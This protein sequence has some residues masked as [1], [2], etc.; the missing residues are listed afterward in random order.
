MTQHL[1]GAD[2]GWLARA[3]ALGET[4]RGVSRPNPAVG[5]VVVR[6]GQI[7]G[8]G[9]T[10]PAGGPHAEVVALAEAGATARGA[11]AYVTLEPCA[12]HGR[13]PPC[14][15]A[16]IAE[17]V[18]RVVIG[19]PDPDGVALDGASRLQAAGLAVT[20]PLPATDLFRGVIARQLEGFLTRVT[21]D[22]PHVTLKLA[23][24]GDGRTH[25]AD[26][27]RWVTGVAARRAVHRWRSAV[28]GVLVGSGTVL[29]DDPHLTVR[30]ANGVP[31]TEQPRPLVLDARLRTP[32][33]ATVVARGA[34]VLTS[35]SA[36]PDRIGALRA[37]GAV[38]EVVPAA[39]PIGLQLSRAL[40]AFARHGINSL[41]AEPGR[42]LAQ[43][44]LDADLVDRLV[45]HVGHDVPGTVVV[46]AVAPAAATV[47]RLERFGGAGP[48]AVIQYTRSR[49]T[50]RDDQE[51]A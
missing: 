2:R 14:T 24:T 7:V 39:E 31:A 22:R 8:E 16:L 13:T 44:L 33:S 40:T 38:V 5:C 12:H 45:V 42:T 46:P 27:A 51:A 4:A 48:D 25:A 43:A 18:G 41:L 34:I 23:Q 26:G 49:S 35:S 20:G 15:D 47:W 10:R 19:H 32:P 37:A 11:T 17:G 6:D 21:R 1:D 3:I 29:D 28:D 50:P 36:D 30:D 9:A